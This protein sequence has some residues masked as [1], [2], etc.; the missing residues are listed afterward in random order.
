MVLDMATHVLLDDGE[1]GELDTQD[2]ETVL[3][4]E[5]CDADCTEA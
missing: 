5:D 1:E 3:V 2:I 4:V